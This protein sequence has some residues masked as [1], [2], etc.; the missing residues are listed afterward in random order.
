MQLI[1]FIDVI[2]VRNNKFLKI[3]LSIYFIILIYNQTKNIF[4]VI[5]LVLFYV[6]LNLLLSKSNPCF[7]N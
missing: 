1:D 7:Y 3:K 4:I 5:F 6:F 2:I